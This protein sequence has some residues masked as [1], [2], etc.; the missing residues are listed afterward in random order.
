MNPLVFRYGHVPGV[1]GSQIYC[2]ILSLT[3]MKNVTL[4]VEVW[5]SIARPALETHG[6]GDV[7]RW[8]G[9]SLSSATQTNTLDTPIRA[10]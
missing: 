2:S 10:L 7:P 9:G 6:G 5:E 3:R 1:S 4:Q 8:G